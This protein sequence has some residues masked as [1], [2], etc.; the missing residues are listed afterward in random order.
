[1]PEHD[2]DMPRPVT[3]ITLPP[4]RE[5]LRNEHAKVKAEVS[6][7]E[8]VPLRGG[9]TQGGF[10]ALH[11]VGELYAD[12][13]DDF[14]VTQEQVGEYADKHDLPVPEAHKEYYAKRKKGI[15]VE[16]KDRLKVEAS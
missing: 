14:A 4:L 13:M 15:A 7:K 2:H 3:S 1:M 12:V 8:E 11:R 5:N 6:A 10:K 16:F 9:K